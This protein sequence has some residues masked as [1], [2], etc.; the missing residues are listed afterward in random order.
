MK[1][2][3]SYGKLLFVILFVLFLPLVSYSVKNTKQDTN[4]KKNNMSKKAI[5]ET[6]IF[7]QNNPLPTESFTTLTYINNDSVRLDLDI[8]K[9]AKLSYPGRQ[10]LII[11]IHGGGF[12]TGNRTHLHGPCKYFSEKGYVTAT[13][14]YRLFMK[15]KDF[16]CDGLLQEKVQ[17]IQYAVSDIWQATSFLIK[18]KEKYNIDISKIFIA[19]SS[20]GAETALHA[21][22]WDYNLMNTYSATLPQQF[23]YA[24]VISGAGAIMDLNLIKKSNQTPILFFHGTCDTIV[25]Y[26]TAAHHYCKTN[27]LGWLM[28][29]GSKSMYEH[30]INNNISAELVTYCGGGHEYADRLFYKDRE[31]IL[32]FINQINSGKKVFSHIVIP[33][34]NDCKNVDEFDFCK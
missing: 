8:F 23:K 32:D 5:K 17:A 2:L 3:S 19:G 31:L 13:V 16:S 9:P 10:P 11:F 26:A 4:L 30:L 28:L 20:A 15:N 22:F 1:Y 24:G 25:P 6:N 21:A 33:T 14:S 7:K 12:S 27:A 29:F 34:N 18:N